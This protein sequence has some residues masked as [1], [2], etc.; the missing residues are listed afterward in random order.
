MKIK[1][2]F[3]S[4]LLGGA[5]FAQTPNYVPSNGLIGYW[6]FNG[7]ANDQSGNSNNGIVNGAT[8]TTDRNGLSN[9]AYNFD[10]VSNYIKISDNSLME[11]S[12]KYTISAW[13]NLSNTPSNQYSII[14]KERQ[15]DATGLSL[16]IDNTSKLTHAFNNGGNYPTVGTSTL[17]NSVWKFIIVTYDGTTAKTYINGQLDKSNTFS[18]TL[19]NSSYDWFIGKEFTTSG[20]GNSGYTNRYF[21]G[22]IDDIGMW[23]RALT[24]QEINTL[25]ISCINPTATITPQ[26]STIFCSGNSVTLNATT[27]SGFTYEWYNN[28]V[29]INNASSSSYN[30]SNSGNYTVKVID[31]ACNS[32]STITS[33]TVN[34]NPIVSLASLN[35]FINNNS[36]TINLVGTPTGGTYIGSGVNGST[37]NP[38]LAGLGNK[39]IT[40]NYTDINNCSGSASRSTIVYD[41]TGIICTAYD[42]TF[43]TVTDTLIINAHFAGLNNTIGTTVIKIYPNPTSDIIY[44]NTGDFTNLS[45]STIKIT[46]A[47][48]Q[49]VFTSLINQQ[50][51]TIN[52]SQ[53]GAK[54]VYTVQ[55]IDGNQTV[56]ETRKIVLQ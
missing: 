19:I 21:K 53:F 22:K 9:S 36:N 54:G 23:N 27:G 20:G 46:N 25:Y 45:G 2:L 56:K 13:I 28:N 5:A 43:I 42:T 4:I 10:G 39:T 52:T 41:T 33:V 48:G 31:G 3:F 24:T 37:F 38:H 34:S 29:I 32:T 16:I 47:I 51:F 1:S 50:L 44:I 17:P 30:T 11:L 55:I 12:N 14:S 8:L 26:S 49:S 7:N 18:Q 6:G 35:A 40:Y 15:Q